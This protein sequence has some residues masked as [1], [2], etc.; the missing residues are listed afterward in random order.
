MENVAVARLP[1]V[2]F[3]LEVKMLV[4]TA[5]IL[6]LAVVVLYPIILLLVNTFVVS[7]PA[8]PTEYGLS[9]WQFA[10][11]D[12]GMLL[13]LWNT[14]RVAVVTQLSTLFT[15]ILF[16]WLIARTNLPGGQWVE[17]FFWVAFFLPTIALVQ[18]WILLFDGGFGLVNQALMWFPF[19]D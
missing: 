2:P 18:A 4:V 1:K 11:S 6:T 12:K 19:I 17:F 16:A 9:A 8:E 5:T 13:A 3:S 10:L 7:K 15:A 14:V